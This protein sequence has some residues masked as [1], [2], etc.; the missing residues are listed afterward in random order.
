ME[1]FSKYFTF[2][3]M[4]NSNQYPETVEANR[5]EAIEHLDSGIKLSLLMEQ[6]RLFLGVPLKETS[7]FRGT[8]LSKAGSFSLTSSH[9]RFEAL[10]CVP[11]GMSVEEAFFKI[12]RN[13]GKF[14]SLRK[15]ILEKVKGK[16][17]LH[18]EVKTKTSDVLAFYTTTDGKNYIRS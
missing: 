13:A 11:I 2:E 12:K 16:L 10:D 7:G 17:W 1:A 4:T 3:A 5:K 9:T 18:I 15:V 14:P 8:T 6:I